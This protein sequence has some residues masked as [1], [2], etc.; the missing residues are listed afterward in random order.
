MMYSLVRSIIVPGA[1]RKIQSIR[2]LEYVPK[3]RPFIV[4]A[5]HVSWFDPVYITA[6]LCRRFRKRILFLAAS[7]KYIW[8]KAVIPIDWHEPAACLAVALSYLRRGLSIGV[9][10]RG[11]QR[12]ASHAKTGVARLARWSGTPI[13][14]VG[15]RNTAPGHTLKSLIEYVRG[16]KSV[17][18][19]IGTPFS[20]A[21]A[22]T[23]THEMLTEDTARIETAIETLL[24]T[25]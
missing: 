2:G 9:F 25:L 17:D 8:T 7:K 18:I 1:L 10:P 21:A 19:S 22:Q 20:L 12:C 13:L 16:R 6:A 5:N 24:A 4:A 3:D 11:D 23:L 14:P 15:I